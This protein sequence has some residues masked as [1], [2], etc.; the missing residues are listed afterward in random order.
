VA[1]WP[2]RRRC[3]R[4]VKLPWNAVLVQSNVA[5]PISG[6][7][8]LLSDRVWTRKAEVQRGLAETETGLRARGLCSMDMICPTVNGMTAYL[9]R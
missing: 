5:R 4:K 3:G 9:H 2:A 1:V 7:R 6:T 8:R